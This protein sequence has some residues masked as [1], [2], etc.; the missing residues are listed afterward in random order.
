MLGKIYISESNLDLTIRSNLHA[1]KQLNI[2][3]TKFFITTKY[4]VL[5]D[6]LYEF[7]YV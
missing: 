4:P 2:L 1:K 7:V 5:L 3:I 6:T